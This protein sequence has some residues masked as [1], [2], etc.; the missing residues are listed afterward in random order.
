MNFTLLNSL[1]VA[2]GNGHLQYFGPLENKID[3]EA[4]ISATYLPDD[5]ADSGQGQDKKDDETRLDADTSAQEDAINAGRK[6]AQSENETDIQ[7]EAEPQVDDVPRSEFQL[8][9]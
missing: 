3:A 7:P 4:A 9:K 1:F 5:G 2:T 8:E 6:G